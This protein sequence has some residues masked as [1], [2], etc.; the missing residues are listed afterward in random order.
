ME[1]TKEFNANKCSLIY[2]F[3]RV[4]VVVVAV[5]PNPPS[6]VVLFRDVDRFVEKPP[7]A[8]GAELCAVVVA[9]APKVRPVD[10]LF[11]GRKVKLH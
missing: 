7:N 6:I 10:M 1:S 4:A 8:G 2:L 3:D 5:K 9:L 11:W